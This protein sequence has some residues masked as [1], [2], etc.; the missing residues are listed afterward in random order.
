MPDSGSRGTLGAG[1]GSLT[2]PPDHAEV[3]CV[4]CGTVYTTALRPTV[5]R[6]TGPADGEGDATAIAGC[7]ECGWQGREGLLEP[8]VLGPHPAHDT[9]GR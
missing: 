4:R 9:H 5:D 1:G 3:L 6:E 8:P 7:P 2:R